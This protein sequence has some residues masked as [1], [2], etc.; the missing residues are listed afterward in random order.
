MIQ[1]HIKRSLDNAHRMTMDSNHQ[2]KK[3]LREEDLGSDTG[4]G[5]AILRNACIRAEGSRI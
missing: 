5:K 4:K 3:D 2:I 1:V